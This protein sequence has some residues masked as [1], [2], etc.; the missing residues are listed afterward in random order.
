MILL[1]NYQ[2]FPKLSLLFCS[3]REKVKF[4]EYNHTHKFEAQNMELTEVCLQSKLG[5][6]KPIYKNKIV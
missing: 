4:E 6:T 2:H 3:L 5:S 1:N